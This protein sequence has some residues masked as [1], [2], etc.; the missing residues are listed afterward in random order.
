[1][2][3]LAII[4]PIVFGTLGALLIL[5]TL[6]WFVRRRRQ[7]QANSKNAAATTT[8]SGAVPPAAHHPLATAN[9]LTRTMVS[10]AAAP[11]VSSTS[12]TTSP[13]T[14]CLL[15]S[16]VPSSSSTTSPR[17]ARSASDVS[18]KAS[19]KRMA[20]PVISAL[21]PDTPETIESL[22][23]RS[24]SS[25]ARSARSD[26]SSILEDPIPMVVVARFIQS[27]DDELAIKPGDK[28]LVYKSY[29][30]GWCLAVDENGN[31]GFVPA[32]CVVETGVL[33]TMLT[34]ATNQYHGPAAI[35]IPAVPSTL[36]TTLPAA[37]AARPP[38]GITSS[39]I[40]SSS[41]TLTTVATPAA[42]AAPV[43]PAPAP[44]E[45]PTLPQLAPSPA[46]PAA[47]DL[48]M[49]TPTPSCVP[50]GAPASR[51]T[52]S[53]STNRSQPSVLTLP[54]ATAPLT[55]PTLGPPPPAVSTL[56]R[57]DPS[58]APPIPP[59]PPLGTL[60]LTMA[61]NEEIATPRYLP[62]TV[63]KTAGRPTMYL[64]EE[65]V[66]DALSAI[67][68]IEEMQRQVVLERKISRAS[69]KAKEE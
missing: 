41:A 34:S 47:A 3:D 54:L 13:A 12:P 33:K 67:E 57:T 68:H 23:R 27:N 65:E 59:P 48:I 55:I 43:V 56:A 37:A 36:A 66:M 49:A 9:Q 51:T 8:S 15:L 4:L 24:E 26:L 39:G 46:A 45:L 61:D 32:A 19:S 53:S 18:S 50:N 2:S 10:D 6:V 16:L 20:A 44:A 22:S 29:S 21:F 40:T 38:S 5:T 35:V 69:R 60:T 64:T 25:L 42:P 17:C 58:L 63:P 14:M 28:V 31:D 52:S 30:D 1:M 62:G 11:V 7:Q